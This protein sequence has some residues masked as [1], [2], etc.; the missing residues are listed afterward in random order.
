MKYSAVI[1]AALAAVA[2]AQDISIF[3]ACSLPCITDAISSATNCSATDYACV[4]SN[5]DALTAAATG[6][7]V[8][9]CGIDVATGQ[10]L[11]ATKQFC[12]NVD[13]SSS[14]SSADTTVTSETTV[15]ETS[16][17]TES[18]TSD[19][20]TTTESATTTVHPISTTKK[21]TNGTATKTTSPTPT[22]VVTAG[23]AVMGSIGSA[24]MLLFGAAA[25][26]F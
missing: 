20:T 25:F 17:S 10:V 6:C 15:S 4:C 2:S 13:T 16:T 22:S 1:V 9:K 5:M 11:P 26:A 21:V 3:P 12:A 24:A 7:V 19:H 23:A 8:D 14:S 18:S